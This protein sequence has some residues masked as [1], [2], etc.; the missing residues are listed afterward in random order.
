MNFKDRYDSTKNNNVVTSHR[1]L[2]QVQAIDIEL[3]KYENPYQPRIIDKNLIDNVIMYRKLR[4]SNQLAEHINDF[5]ELLKNKQFSSLIELS[6]SIEEVGEL[7][8]P[9]SLLKK[10]MNI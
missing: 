7:I 8:Q 9:I 3:I 5:K 4:S 10:L 6:D 1:D 2:Q